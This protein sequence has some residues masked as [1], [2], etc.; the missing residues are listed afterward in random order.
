MVLSI[1]KSFWY[2]L[3]YLF[4][5]LSFYMFKKND[6]KFNGISWL[7]VTAFLIMCF[8]TFI[9]GILSLVAIP[10]NILTLSFFNLSAGLFFWCKTVKSKQR[11]RY[12]FHTVD[13]VAAGI[14]LAAVA[15]SYVK[16]FGLDFE[17]NFKTSDAAVHMKNAMDIFNT[18]KVTGM[19]FSPLNNALLIQLLSPLTAAF[20]Y[21]KLFMLSDMC[22]FFLSG[23][24]FFA[25]IRRYLTKPFMQVFGVFL[26]LAYSMGYPLNNALFGFVY[27]GTSVS[28]IA[29][30]VFL[31]DCFIHEDLSRWFNAILLG[32][33]CL[34]VLVCYTMFA[35]ALYV[36]VFLCLCLDMLKHKNLFKR[37]SLLLLGIVFVVPFFMGIYYSYFGMF[38]SNSGLSLP[39]VLTWEGAIYRDLYS[40]FVIFIPFALYGLYKLIQSKQ[41]SAG[42]TTFV[43]MLLFTG[44]LF[45]MGIFG[46][47]S[48]YYYYKCYY[49]LWFLTF[50]M[51]V[52]GLARLAEHA[53]FLIATYA[54]VWVLIA[55]IN[56]SGLENFLVA[57]RATFAP[58]AKSTAFFDIYN[59]NYT[60]I[61]EPTRYV[62]PEMELFKYAHE[63]LMTEDN[64]RIPNIGQY[65]TVYWYEALTNQRLEDAFWWN[66][67][68]KTLIK[69]L[70]NGMFGKYVIVHNHPD[71]QFALDAFAG[72]PIVFQ[73]SFGIIYSVTK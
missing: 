16:L 40:N 69:N 63:N 7:S 73:N 64:P 29:L 2:I 4:L 31:C 47:V 23:T 39:T 12:S 1:I 3:T 51:A 8:N 56:F 6:T 53:K 19:Y 27:L 67:D 20:D 10:V 5:F 34:S 28:V 48:G 59:Y 62:P 45:F 65:E 13:F 66:Q 49:P 36:G 35:P 52:Y 22:M 38:N 50:Y 25:A 37:K 71:G 15:V 43:V 58:A 33:G 70:K 42:A 60:R 18:G 26:T 17:I 68:E 14:L 54:L 21:Y 61:I 41:P 11:Q 44:V 30:V 32:F 46:K 9:A 57:K 72:Y 55:V 24:L